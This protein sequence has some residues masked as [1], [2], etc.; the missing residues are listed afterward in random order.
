MYLGGFISAGR[1]CRISLKNENRMAKIIVIGSSNTDMVVRTPKL[2]IPGETVLGGEFLMNQGGKGA[3]QAVAVHRLGGN[4]VFVTKLGCD[5]FGDHAVSVFRE[6]GMKLDYISR[7]QDIASGIALITVDENAENSIVVAPGANMLIGKVEIDGVI[8]EMKSG[9]FL[10][11]QL[12]IPLSTVE[13]AVWKASEKGVNVVLNPA[14]VHKL[15]RKLFNNLYLITPNRVEAEMLTGVQITKWNDAVKA[16]NIF[17][18]MGIPNVIITLGSD[19]CLVKDEESIYPIEACKVTPV[20]TTAAGDTFNG[21]LCVALAEG[22]QMKE[23]VRFA[24]KAAS[25]AVTRVGAQNSIPY[26]N[27]LK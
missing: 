17:A 4:L 16:A 15:P 13:Y 3:N 24:S 25:I 22:K 6:E 19:G 18:E 26:R 9:D 1:C 14:P 10:L 8:N 11:L 27:E 7:D 21:A 23:A 20:D 5:I 2:P 12:E